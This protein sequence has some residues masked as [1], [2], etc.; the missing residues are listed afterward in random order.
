MKIIFI[1]NMFLFTVLL[2]ACTGTKEKSKEPL[3][4]V[5]NNRFYVLFDNV[6]GLITGDDVLIKGIKVGEVNA[7]ALLN[8]KRFIVTLELKK[9]SEIPVDSKFQMDSD[10]LGSRHIYIDY[11]D[12]AGFMMSGDTIEG[13]GLIDL[14]DQIDMAKDRADS[15]FKPILKVRQQMESNTR[16][17]LT[18]R[19]EALEYIA[20]NFNGESERTLWIAD[21][22]I[23]P[24]GLNMAI[25]GDALLKAGYM[26]NGAEQKEGYRIYKYIKE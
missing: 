19:E 23:D 9:D 16:K 6:D 7:I 5:T 10:L 24:S 15:L 14:K 21:T 13:I 18:T 8:K 26:P 22:L 25:L 3:S 11:S 12:H 17:P 4:E 1:L 2:S 20:A